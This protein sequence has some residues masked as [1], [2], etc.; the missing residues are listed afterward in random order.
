M[1]MIHA[2]R[3]K[4]QV[5]TL[6]ITGWQGVGGEAWGLFRLGGL[7]GEMAFNWRIKE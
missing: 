1:L 6:K 4:Y 7:S 5:H 3:E 2:L